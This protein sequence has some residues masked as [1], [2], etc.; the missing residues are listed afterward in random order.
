MTYSAIDARL[1]DSGATVVAC[2]C[3]TSA[4]QTN[5]VISILK[6]D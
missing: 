2:V 1:E 5:F 6:Y 3:F 4:Q